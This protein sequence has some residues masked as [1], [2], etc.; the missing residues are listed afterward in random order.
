MADVCLAS[1]S[2]TVPIRCT[3]NPTM[4]GSEG[5]IVSFSAGP[6]SADL[7]G[8]EKN[9]ALLVEAVGEE[10]QQAAGAKDILGRH[11]ASEPATTRAVD[12]PNR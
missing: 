3:Q 12:Y 5:A 1:N 10:C 2:I 6:R 4:F 9:G 11:R 7:R 8:V